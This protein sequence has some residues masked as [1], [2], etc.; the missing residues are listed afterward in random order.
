[1]RVEEEQARF[2][3]NA[4][5][6]EDSFI[7]LGYCE[8]IL[9]RF[10]GRGRRERDETKIINGFWSNQRPFCRFTHLILSPSANT[11]GPFVSEMLLESYNGQQILG[12]SA[13][14]FFLRRPTVFCHAR[15]HFFSPWRSLSE[16]FPRI[17]TNLM[18]GNMGTNF[19]AL[20]VFSRPVFTARNGTEWN[21]E[22]EA[23]C[24]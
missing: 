6:I 12:I 19:I 10:S 21:E 15:V 24:P 5:F 9:N 4:L 11:R 13:E 14:L 17:P 18:V 3:G 2:P 1:M 7:F 22:R 20:K 23:H 16:W 8:Q